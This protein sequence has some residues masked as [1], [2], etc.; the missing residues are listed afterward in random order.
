MNNRYTRRQ[1]GKIALAAV[2]TAGLLGTPRSARGLALAAID[3]RIKG[4]RIGAITYSFRAI[5]DADAIVTAMA[6]I[7]LGEAELMSN[8]AEALAGAPTGRGASEALATWRRST[9]PDTWRP[10]RRKFDNAG[11]RLRLLCFNMNVRTTTDADVEYAFAMAGALGVE[12]ISTSTQV[13]MAKR[14]APFADKHQMRVAYHGHA[15]VT[16]PDEVSTPASFATCLSHSKYH[17]VNLDIGHFTAAG[18]DAVAFLKENHARI[19][20]LHLKD[21][22]NPANGGANVPWGQGD[23]PIKEVLQLL[24]REKWDIPANIEFEYPGDPL[25]EIP[26]CFQFCKDALA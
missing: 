25:V 18:F 6:Q 19:S 11:I 4:V 8:H 22:Q 14:I 13:S 2:P 16:D 26:K 3:S 7:G 9:S 17:A 1:F 15:N 24:S 20:N 5:T 10:V 23:T 12:A 21:R